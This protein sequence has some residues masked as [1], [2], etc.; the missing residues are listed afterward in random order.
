MDKMQKLCGLIEDELKKVAEKGLNSGNLEVAY[1]LVDMY[2]DLKNTEYWDIKSEYY[3][4]VLDEMQGGYS[5][6]GFLPPWTRRLR[7]QTLPDS[8][9]LQ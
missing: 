6:A 9:L 4:G 2:K 7:S 3:M 5:Q 8:P 1:K